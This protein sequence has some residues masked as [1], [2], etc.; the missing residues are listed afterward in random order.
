MEVLESSWS[1]QPTAAHWP[2]KPSARHAVT[3]AEL[4]PQVFAQTFYFIFLAS[5]NFLREGVLTNIIGFSAYSCLIL[6]Q[7][8]LGNVDSGDLI[9]NTFVAVYNIMLHYGLL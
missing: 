3:H 6:R 1:E 2:A 5:R 4:F 9:D 7:V 8:L